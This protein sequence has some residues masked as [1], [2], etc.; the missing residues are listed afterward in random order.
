MEVLLNKLY[1]L[2]KQ[3]IHILQL[4]GKLFYNSYYGII[5]GECYNEL[6]LMLETETELKK[7]VFILVI[8][9]GCLQETIVSSPEQ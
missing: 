9:T 7:R 5:D 2:S 4:L 6:Q 1:V 8:E 3:S